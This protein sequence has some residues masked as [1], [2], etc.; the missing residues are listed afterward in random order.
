MDADE[1]VRVVD[2]ALVELHGRRVTELG[3]DGSGLFSHYVNLLGQGAILREDEIRA[4]RLVR[5]ALPAYAGYAVLRAGLGELAF[6]LNGA[7]LPVIACE[8]NTARVQALEAGLDHLVK[9][10]LLSQKTL[11]VVPGFVPDRV[12]VRPLLGIA[13]DFVFNLPLE[14]DGAFCSGLRQLDGLLVNP[15]LFIRLRETQSE[16][17]AAVDFLRSLG[18]ISLTEFPAEQMLHFSRQPAS[19]QE[20]AVAIAPGTTMTREATSLSELDRL[21]DHL[22]SLAPPTTPQRADT[23]WVERRRRKFDL[24]SALGDDE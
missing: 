22:M 4:F 18:F 20:A 10:T 24:R 19:R 17:A 13:T 9:A 23:T 16:Q 3:I 5:E 1:L 15:R 14:R 11:T 7:G 8:P 12:E 6:L 2:A 21:V